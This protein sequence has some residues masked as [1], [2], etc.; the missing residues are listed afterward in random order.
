M[1]HKIISSQWFLR[2]KPWLFA[3]VTNSHWLK[4]HLKDQKNKDYFCVN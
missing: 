3:E 2:F 1:L 4:P